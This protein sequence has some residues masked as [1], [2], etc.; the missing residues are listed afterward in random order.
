MLHQLLTVLP[1]QCIK[2]C[3]KIGSVKLNVFYQYAQMIN[4]FAVLKLVT[5]FLEYKEGLDKQVTANWRAHC[6][7]VY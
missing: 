7:A 3:L 1:S 2:K 4:L 5:L 6:A